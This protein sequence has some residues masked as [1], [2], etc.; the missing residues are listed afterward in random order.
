MKKLQASF[1]GLNAKTAISP[2]LVKANG[3]GLRGGW[4]RIPRVPQVRSQHSDNMLK[5]PRMTSIHATAKFLKGMKLIT[6]T[7]FFCSFCTETL[8]RTL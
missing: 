3:A 4:N 2:T 1:T 5:E 6:S 7:E 8:I